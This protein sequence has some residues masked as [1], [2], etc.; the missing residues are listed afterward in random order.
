MCQAA[1]V[2]I[3]DVTFVIPHGRDIAQ[4]KAQLLDAV[5]VGGAPVAIPTTGSIVQI[6]VTRGTRVRIE[7]LQPDAND[8]ESHVA[9]SPFIHEDWYYPGR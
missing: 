6:F 3:D 2:V 5:R 4:L 7:Y 9:E 8:S 1:Q